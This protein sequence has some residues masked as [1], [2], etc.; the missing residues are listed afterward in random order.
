MHRIRQL[1]SLNRLNVREAFAAMPAEPSLV[2]AQSRPR[3]V[4]EHG[5]THGGTHGGRALQL[6][7]AIMT[8]ALAWTL[9]F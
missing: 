8:G 6:S 2:P 1:G 7:F 9:D 5:G 3:S 4:P